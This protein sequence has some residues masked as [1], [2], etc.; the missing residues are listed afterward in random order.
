[1]PQIIPGKTPSVTEN[2]PGGSHEGKGQENAEILPH[3][4]EP[5]CDDRLP[6]CRIEV[7]P[8]ELVRVCHP[9]ESKLRSICVIG[10]GREQIRKLPQQER[11]DPEQG[12]QKHPSLA[13]FPHKGEKY[14]SLTTQNGGDE[15]VRMEEWNQRKQEGQRHGGGAVFPLGALRWPLD[16]S[17]P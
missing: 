1:K 10:M 13:I 8:T 11:A 5:A 14:P 7:D 6:S 2:Q 3:E 17:R 4:A 16:K 12:P 15:G 9:A